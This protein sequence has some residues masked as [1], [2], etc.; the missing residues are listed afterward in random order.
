MWICIKKIVLAVVL[1]NFV[2][3]LVYLRDY[4]FY[5]DKEKITKSA[6]NVRDTKYILYW[7]P[8]WDSETFGF[9]SE[10]YELFRNCRFKNC[11]AT[12]NRHII[13]LDKFSAIVFHGAQYNMKKHGVP[14]V[15]SPKQR[16]VYANLEPPLRAYPQNL[17]KCSS[18][19]NWTMTY[20]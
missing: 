15:R 8:M 19:Y 1:V 20:R 11:F 5:Y 3:L 2:I 17:H 18:F 10:G 16:Y 6:I 14:S 13:S 12:H 7:I 4:V 9:E